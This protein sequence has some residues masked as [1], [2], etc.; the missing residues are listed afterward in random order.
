MFRNGIPLTPERIEFI[1]LF[2][3]MEIESTENTCML[4]NHRFRISHR[5][6]VLRHN[7]HNCKTI[8]I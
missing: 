7:F 1:R 5:I 4:N 6:I 2:H 8:S 3:E